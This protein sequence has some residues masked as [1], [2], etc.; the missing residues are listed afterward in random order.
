MGKTWSCLTKAMEGNACTNMEESFTGDLLHLPEQ[1]IRHNYIF[2][3]IFGS[4][5]QQSTTQAVFLS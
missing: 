1:T 4:L 3:N 5:E 2:I